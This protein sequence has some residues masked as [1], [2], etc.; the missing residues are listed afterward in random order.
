MVE[1]VLL[2]YFERPFGNETLSSGNLELGITRKGSL[3]E[4]FSRTLF[5]IKAVFTSMDTLHRVL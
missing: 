5:Q 4:E 3:L 1:S 2:S